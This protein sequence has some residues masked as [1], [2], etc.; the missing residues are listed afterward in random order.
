VHTVTKAVSFAVAGDT[1]KN[2]KT[3]LLSVQ[4]QTLVYVIVAVFGAVSR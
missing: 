3:E 2:D 1:P 4:V